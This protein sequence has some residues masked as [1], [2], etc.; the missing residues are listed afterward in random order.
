MAI[1]R[2]DMW[3]AYLE[4]WASVQTEVFT[5]DAAVKEAL[6]LSP[7]IR[8]D[9]TRAVSRMIHKLGYNS[10]YNFKVGKIEYYPKDGVLWDRRGI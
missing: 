10:R 1:S 7:D 6:V 3:P 4:Q 9:P 5:A 2:M 8:N